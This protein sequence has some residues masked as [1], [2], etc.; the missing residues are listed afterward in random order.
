MLQKVHPKS[1]L[2]AL[3]KG[4]HVDEARGQFLENGIERNLVN[5]VV[6][7]EL[8]I[9]KAYGGNA[10]AVDCSDSTVF[11]LG[12]IELRISTHHAI[13]Y[14]DIEI[15]PDVI[16]HNDKRGTCVCQGLVVGKFK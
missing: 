16:R 1:E 4:V 14:H 10:R 11:K 6:K 15:F 7:C 12:A 2:I 9:L 13:A 8:D 5:R 3:R